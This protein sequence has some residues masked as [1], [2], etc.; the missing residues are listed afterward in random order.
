M[1]NIDFY[2]YYFFLQRTVDSTGVE[3]NEAPGTISFLFIVAWWI[4]T[5]DSVG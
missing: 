2:Y 3:K 4:N 5:V 1:S